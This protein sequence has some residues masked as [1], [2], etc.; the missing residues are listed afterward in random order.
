MA[1]AAFFGVLVAVF[2]IGQVVQSSTVSEKS[3]QIRALEEEIAALKSEGEKLE[4]KLAEEQTIG[5]VEARAVSLGLIPH[6]KVEY[7]MPGT[8]GV[9]RK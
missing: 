3:R 7:V 9:A 4:L 8:S 1:I 2:G 6:D 5:A